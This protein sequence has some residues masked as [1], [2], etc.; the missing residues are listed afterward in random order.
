MGN[1]PEGSLGEKGGLPNN[2]VSATNPP[3]VIDLLDRNYHY[4]P[5]ATKSS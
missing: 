4:K 1:M 5:L 3:A 2:V